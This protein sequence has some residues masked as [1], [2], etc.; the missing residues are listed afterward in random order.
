MSENKLLIPAILTRYAPRADK[1]WGISLNINEPSPEQKVIIDKMFQNPIYVLMKDAE[2]VK[3]EQSLI[4]S[5]E[6]KEHQIKTKSQRL[7]SVLFLYWK[8]LGKMEMTDKEFYESEM[9]RIIN[10]YKNKLD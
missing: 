3:E 1:S 7:R 2:I 9:E 10:H 5:L 6:A 4:D 8:Q